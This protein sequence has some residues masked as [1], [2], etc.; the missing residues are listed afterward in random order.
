MIII[1]TLSPIPQQASSDTW[2]YLRCVC[3]PTYECW[4]RLHLFF[5]LNPSLKRSLL[6]YLFPLSTSTMKPV[7]CLV[8]STGSRESPGCCVVFV[9]MLLF[10][11]CICVLVVIQNIR[12]YAIMRLLEIAVAV[13]LWPAIFFIR[14]YD[15]NHTG[16]FF[17]GPPSEDPIKSYHHHHHNNNNNIL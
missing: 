7:F 14:N 15:P 10:A 11:L 9:L 17:I 2:Q 5:S 6:L 3:M 8:F 13:L 12:R 16:I 4:I 1:M